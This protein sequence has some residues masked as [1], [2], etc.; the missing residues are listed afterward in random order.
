M[1]KVIAVLFLSLSLVSRY[2]AQTDKDYKDLLTMFVSEKYEKCL[3]KAEGYTLDDETKKDALPYLFMSRCYFEMSKKDEFKEKYPN[4]FK[5]SM[6][7]ISKYGS[8]D[9]EHKYAAEYED[10][11]A[12]ISP[13]FQIQ[14]RG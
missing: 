13:K 14:N 1:K 7:Y 4:A 11:F 10:F 9:K 5:D 8:K 2:S 12:A 3:Y 6:K